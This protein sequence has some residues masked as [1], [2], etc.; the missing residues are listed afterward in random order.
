[1]EVADDDSIHHRCVLLAAGDQREVREAALVVVAHV[2]AAVEHDGLAVE[3]HEHAAPAD[4]LASTQDEQL[5]LGHRVLLLPED[6]N[7][8][9]HEAS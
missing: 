7:E 4:I 3:V 9:L 5:D 1:M 6:V 8:A 2:H